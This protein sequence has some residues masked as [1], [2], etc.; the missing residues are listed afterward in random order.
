MTELPALLRDDFSEPPRAYSPVTM[1]WWSGEPL[2]PARLR[3]QLERFA[4]GGVFNLVIINLAASGPLHGCDA[5]DPPF[6]SA[7]WWEIVEDVCDYAHEL[8]V[9]L[10]L[11]DQIGFSGAGIQARLVSEHP[12]AAGKWLQRTET[13]LDGEGELRCP[14]GGQA[15]AA[16]A[17]PA[18]G[19]PTATEVD[20]GVARWCGSGQCRLVLYY[21]VTR[22]FDYLSNDACGRLLDRVHGEVERRLPGHLGTTIVGTFQDELPSVPTWSDGLADEFTRRHGYDLR[23]RLADLFD[24]VDG[25]SGRVRRDYHATRAAL[26]EEAFFTPLARWHGRHGLL[27]GCDQQDPSRAGHPVGSVRQYGDYLRTHRWFSAPGS[28]HH[29]DAH[30]H[31]SLAHL[32]GG[33]RTWI[34]AFHSTGWGGTLEETFDWLLP[35]LR[36][37]AT[38]YNPH[39]SYYSTR[40]GWWEWAP[41]STDWRQPYWVHHDRFAAAVSRLC[42]TL[43][44]GR[45]VCDVAVLFPTATV[46][47][48][49][50]LDSTSVDAERAHRTYLE[51]IGDMTWFDVVP[52]TL[53][54][55]QQDFD[56]VDDDSVQRGTVDGGRLRVA[57]EAYAAVLLPA[58]TVLDNA[59]AT[60]LRELVEA[61]GLVIAVGEPPADSSGPGSE[62]NCLAACFSAGDAVLVPSADDIGV[63]LARLSRRVETSVPTLV[64]EVDGATLVFLTAAA[65]RVTDAQVSD[66]AARGAGQGWTDVTY[67]FDPT[68]YAET[69]RIR[70][71]GADGPVTLLEPFSGY[72][73]SLP[74]T[75]GE[76]GLEVDVPFDDGPAALLVLGHGAEAPTQPPRLDAERDL[77]HLWQVDVVPTM[78]NRWGDLSRPA[79]A[80]G[81][82]VARWELLHREERPGEDG[83]RDGWAAPDAGEAGWAQARAT[84][85]PRARVSAARDPAG[86]PNDAGDA[87]EVVWSLSRGI[88][89]D[90]L[91]RE[92]LGPK[93]HVPEEFLD[94]GELAAGTSVTVTLHVDV[95]ET[96]TPYLAVGAPTAK[97]A[98]IGGVEVPLDD[99][100]GYLAIGPAHLEAGT[101]RVELHLTAE[102]T[103]R[104]RAHAAFVTEP[105]GY[106]RP[107][108]MS[109]PDPSADSSPL[110]FT[111]HVTLPAAPSDATLQVAATA[112]CRVLVD[113]DEVGRQGGF[114]PYFE[115]HTTQVSRYDL[116]GRLHG[117]SN[118]LALEVTELDVP[119]AVL[120]DGRVYCDE[121]TVDVTSDRSWEVRRGGTATP[122]RLR[123]RQWRDPGYTHLWRRPHPLP[124]AGWL[125]GGD[126]AGVV[127]DLAPAAGT[128]ATV[129]WLRFDIPPGAESMH[130]AVHGHVTVYVDGAE[131]TNCRDGG[132]EAQRR[133]VDLSGTAGRRRRVCAL[134]VETL[135]ARRGGAIL[136]EPVT[137][138]TGRG[139]MSLGDW[140]ERG[141]RGYSGGVRY[142]TTLPAD[143]DVAGAERVVLDLG[144][145]RGTAEVTVSG[146][147]AGIRVCS[148]YRF[149]LTG[150]LGA[151][152]DELEIAVFNTLG[153]HLDA[154]SPTHFVFGGQRVSGILGPVR[155]R[156][157]LG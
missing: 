117:G 59:T 73:R 74:Y 90:P 13:T 106:R 77:G 122:V 123:R 66:P 154:T 114:D 28:D 24:D 67:S 19:S 25:D 79:F 116:G 111:R 4:E 92:T 113:G 147:P 3:W 23:A 36:A 76:D 103:T 104:V 50:R 26:A 119:A 70:V 102:E 12:P 85:G 112:P 146:T 88:L 93:G 121:T 31:S 45:H 149:D 46:Q 139:V 133:T 107:E 27:V 32:Y 38:L 9:S 97:Q 108:W 94:L 11:Y 65:P 129:E 7:R 137:F 43:S 62:V 120:V 15:I 75:A 61:G 87:R 91:H 144:R 151:D 105:A 125:E 56:V 8:G 127:L 140:E 143:P 132:N 72:A 48:G 96:V 89:K 142:R 80:D 14:P 115:R 99:E 130:L 83:R 110:V 17:F 20:G 153:P 44:A 54:R 101:N 155:L 131:V 78:D 63:A 10:W 16:T 52:G 95:P 148:P 68:R 128:E 64:R 51:L 84:F 156:W 81:P 82:P 152:G 86:Q 30:I 126:D 37:G 22:G 141:L 124:G 55:L 18:D 2:D 35:W 57:G 118:E 29:G 41:P 150:L 145:V 40:G 100:G 60:R 109:S 34:E 53:D 39:A 134:R 49:T 157:A 1:W 98:W 69:A 47:A 136:A 58:C 135:P 33:K 71:P 138:N 21:V 42:A 6:F 5:D